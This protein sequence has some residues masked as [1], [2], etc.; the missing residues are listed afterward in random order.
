ME[1]CVMRKK[2]QVLCCTIHK[3][4]FTQF[5]YLKLLSK[6]QHRSRGEW[7]GELLLS[8]RALATKDKWQL[9]VWL[10]C[11]RRFR[12]DL[13]KLNPAFY[14]CPPFVDSGEKKIL[15]KNV[16]LESQLNTASQPVQHH[17]KYLHR[18]LQS[19]DSNP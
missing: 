8:L 3:D 14:I 15:P 5:C 6:T 19:F 17:T 9:N 7:S 2:S 16:S 18:M 1:D 10:D 11:A 12:T 4:L 13:N